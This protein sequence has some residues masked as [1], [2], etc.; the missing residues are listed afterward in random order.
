MPTKHDQE[1]AEPRRNVWTDEERAAMQASAR[2][3]KAASRPQPGGGARRGPAGPARQHRQDAGGRPRDGASGSTRSCRPPCR[4]SCRR[5]TTACRPTRRRARTARSICFFKPKS[6]FKV[7][8]STFGFQPDASLDD[9]EMWPVEFAVIEADP[10]GRGADRRAREESRGLSAGR[11]L[12]RD[13]GPRRAREQPP[14]RQP[15]HPEA[16]AD[17]VHRRFGLGQELAG[18]R[19]DRRRVAAADQRDLQR[20]R[21]G[22]HAHAG[23][24]R[25]RLARRADDGDHPRPGAD[26]RQRPLDRR[27]GHRR[28]RDAAGRLQPDRQAAHRRAAGV[29]VQHPVGQRRRRD[30]VRARRGQDREPHASASPAGCAR[31]ARAWAPPTTST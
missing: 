4:R 29:L 27:H 12:G 8:Y 17:R 11:R 16:P 14:R 7:R 9:G 21:A 5:P 19:H 18:V 10:G 30:Q 2:E 28:E 22:L 1:Q 26:G 13:R 20:V 24:A 23:P 3:R 31:A 15:R 6:K 25:R